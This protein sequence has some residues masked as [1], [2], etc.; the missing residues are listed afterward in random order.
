MDFHVNLFNGTY[1]GFGVAIPQHPADLLSIYPRKYFFFFCAILGLIL[2]V[3]TCTLS[4]VS[5]SSSVSLGV[6]PFD[7][8]RKR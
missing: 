1:P 5:N 8:V 3:Y 6:T 4:N 7:N 2:L